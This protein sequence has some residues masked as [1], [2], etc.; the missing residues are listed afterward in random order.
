MVAGMV[1]SSHLWGYLADT[2]GRRKVLI[3]TLLLDFLCAI[4]GSFAHTFWLF[5]VFRFLNGFFICGPSAVVYVYLGEFH[6]AEHRTK[7]IMWACIFISIGIISLPGLA[8]LVIPLKWSFDTPWFPYSS[9][10][11]FVALCGVPSLVTCIIMALF[12]PESPKFYQAIGQDEE[13]LKALR[14]IYT[15]NKGNSP[16]KY[17][18]K[19]IMSDPS[20]EDIEE[21]GGT[22]QSSG[23]FT[24]IWNQTAPLFQT[25]H[26]RNTVIACL[27]QLG[28]YASFNS[29]L[30]WLPD[31]FNR[32]A[33]YSS[34]HPNQTATVCEILS[35][36][37]KEGDT[38]LSPENLTSQVT[39]LTNNSSQPDS[40]VT[41]SCVVNIDPIVF[42]N[43]LV[44]GFTSAMA[45]LLVSQV[46]N[47]VNKNK[48]VAFALAASGLT[49]LG[50]YFVHTTAEVLP[51]SCIYVALPGMCVS[52]LSG[53]VID[54]FP[55]HLSTQEYATVSVASEEEMILVLLAVDL[56]CP[57]VLLAVD[58][59][60]LSV[61]LIAVPVV[62]GFLLVAARGHLLPEVVVV[63]EVILL[64][65]VSQGLYLGI[66]LV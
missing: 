25:P 15:V 7:A 54:I 65:D 34:S 43:T 32:L 9:W 36:L 62:V 1:A 50:M 11:L 61:L 53:I 14:Y 57:S 48:I 17:P 10:R 46:V 59:C 37:K 52:V 12:L 58:L 66:L 23:V 18:V 3:A 64:S 38:L 44:I 2:R 4:A 30:L 5:V 33:V 29:L 60:C 56:C 20:Q 35:I 8:W 39:V 40:N 24:S 16:D 51:L 45:Y 19:A 55:T 6:T 42:Q 27:I 22:S 26:L 13:A 63:V 28:L 47:H 41:S 21:E 31:L 49:I